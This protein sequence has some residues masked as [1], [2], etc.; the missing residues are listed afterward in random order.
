MLARIEAIRATELKELAAALTDR[1]WP[2]ALA[3]A[4]LVHHL[5][6]DP[7]SIRL[8]AVCQLL[9]RQLAAAWDTHHQSRSG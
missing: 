9:N 2:D 6:R 1:R 3:A 8:L 4:E 5:R 7:A